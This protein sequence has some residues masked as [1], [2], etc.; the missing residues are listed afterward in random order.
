MDSGRVETYKQLAARGVK[1]TRAPS[2]E[3]LMRWSDEGEMKAVDGC[4]V[5]E[6]D[7]YCADH[8]APSWMLKLGLI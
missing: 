3:T 7:G 1:A 5:Y 6:D 2:L 8:H 4:H